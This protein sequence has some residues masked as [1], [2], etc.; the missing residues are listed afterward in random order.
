MSNA[1]VHC[2]S[3]TG[4]GR[5]GSAAETPR[6]DGQ[7]RTGVRRLAAAAAYGGR[8]GG[9]QRKGGHVARSSRLL[10]F[11]RWGSLRGRSRLIGLSRC[12]ARTGS[13]LSAPRVPS[14]NRR[15]ALRIVSSLR[16][17]IAATPSRTFWRRAAR[18][19]AHAVTTEEVSSGG[20]RQQCDRRQRRVRHIR[21]DVRGLTRTA[22]RRLRAAAT[23]SRATSSRAARRRGRRIRETGNRSLYFTARE[24]RT[25]ADKRGRPATRRLLYQKSHCPRRGAELLPAR[26]LRGPTVARK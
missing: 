1:R 7:L 16:R 21:I 24:A 13:Q 8:G 4:P 15:R 22:S 3:L 20:G 6:G 17:I 26:A 12:R 10:R 18:Q 2:G 11:S 5:G 25:R 19:R 23:P 14:R 9:K